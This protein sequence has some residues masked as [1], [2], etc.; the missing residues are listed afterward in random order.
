M[1]A[2]FTHSLPGQYTA[3]VQSVNCELSL[4][5]DDTGCLSGSFVADGE[6]LEIMGGVPNTYGEVF[7]LIREPG[8]DT[9]AVFRAAPHEMNLIFEFNTPGGDDLTHLGNAQRIVFR[10]Q[11]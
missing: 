10:R 3:S 8:G 6:H 11:P 5:L 1:I 9:M 7:G 2:A 4:R